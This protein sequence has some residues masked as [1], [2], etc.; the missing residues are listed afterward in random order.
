MKGNICKMEFIDYETH[1]VGIYW[2][3]SFLVFS[4]C[5][6]LQVLSLLPSN[7]N[8]LW[9]NHLAVL[10]NL[11]IFVKICTNYLLGAREIFFCPCLG[12]DSRTYSNIFSWGHPASHVLVLHSKDQ[13]NKYS[14]H[15]SH[16][17]D[18]FVWSQWNLNRMQRQILNRVLPSK[19]LC[20]LL[21]QT[22]LTEIHCKKMV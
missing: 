9:G 13:R 7:K 5:H 2:T 17:R 21:I 15:I 19:K 12:R 11:S 8:T 14:V 16:S 10:H 18:F 1:E 20:I 3:G 6:I 22:S 4:Q